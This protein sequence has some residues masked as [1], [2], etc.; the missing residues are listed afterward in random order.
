MLR[1]QR[2]RHKTQ[3]EMRKNLRRSKKKVKHEAEEAMKGANIA[4]HDTEEANGL[5]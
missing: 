1:K 2:K 5:R 4:L 3:D